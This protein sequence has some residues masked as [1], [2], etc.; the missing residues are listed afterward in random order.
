MT[1]A[2]VILNWN[3]I[4]LLEQFLPSVVEYSPESTVYIAD[5]ASSDN[6]VIYIMENF[7]KVKI[8]KNEINGGYS[9]GYNDAL[10]F[11]KEDIFIL[12]NSDV[13][14]T[15][16][17]L[18]PILLLFKRNNKLGAVQPKILSYKNPEYFEYAGAAGGFIDKLGYPY[19]RGRI[20]EELEKDE[21]QYNNESEIFWASGACLCISREAF[22]RVGGLDEDYFAHQ[23]EID[24]CWRLHNFGYQVRYTPDSVVY[25]VGGATLNSMNPHKT[26]YNFRNSLYNL[27]KNLPARELLWVLPLRMILDAFAAIKFLFEGQFAHFSAIFRAHLNFYGMIPVMIKKRKKTPQKLAFF[28]IFSVVCSHYLLGKKKYSELN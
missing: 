7:P 12:L 2:V 28:P 13:Q 25:H 21:G 19:C 16:D 4:Q 9:K 5:N 27:V 26:F 18:T 14:V 3:G 22:F 24:V 6:S 15:P 23:E 10:S 11:L 1:I 20:F 17:W 8:I